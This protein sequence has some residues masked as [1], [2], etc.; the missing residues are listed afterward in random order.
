MDKLI[1]KFSRS[2]QQKRKGALG[3]VFGVV[4]VVVLGIV[5]ILGAL[6]FFAFGNSLPTGLVTG[7]QSS[8][9]NSIIATGAAAIS[10]LEVVLIVAAAGLIIAAV[11]TYM[12]LGRRRVKALD[13]SHATQAGTLVYKDPTEN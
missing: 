10:L 9:L 5:L 8:T 2:V 11:F 6:V 1:A 4:T 13:F 7:A 12:A 3:I